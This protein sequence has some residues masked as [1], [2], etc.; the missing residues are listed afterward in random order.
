MSKNYFFDDKVEFVLQTDIMRAGSHI[1]HS[2]VDGHKEVLTFPQAINFNLIINNYIDNF[3]T[4]N[5]EDFLNAFCPLLYHKK[6]SKIMG[7][8]RDFEFDWDEFRR[9]FLDLLSKYDSIQDKF[10]FFLEAF[11]YAYAKANKQDLSKIR[12]VYM[13]L[14]NYDEGLMNSLLDSF[15]NLKVLGLIRNPVNNIYSSFVF[16]R[17]NFYFQFITQIYSLILLHYYY[18]NLKEKLKERMKLLR[19]EDLNFNTNNIIEEIA[20][21]LCISLD[22]ILFVPTL[23]SREYIQNRSE[24]NFA[25]KGF[26]KDKEGY[27]DRV[28]NLFSEDDI[29]FIETITKNIISTYKYD[30][31]STKLMDYDELIKHRFNSNFGLRGGVKRVFKRYKTL[32]DF[33]YLFKVNLGISFFK[34]KVIN[35]MLRLSN[36]K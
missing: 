21:F 5:I 6:D 22:D 7:D 15:K 34:R 9:V 24:D 27:F 11:H 13:H 29:R 35:K 23:G 20:K 33:R 2:I 36:F 4:F 16:D 10:R 30:F 31:L 12:V 19:L 18:Y 14:H 25:L 32:N 17:D 3:N 1:F 28:K 8:F 26:A